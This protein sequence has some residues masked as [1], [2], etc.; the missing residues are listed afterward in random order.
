MR[1]KGVENVDTEYFSR[2]TSKTDELPIRNSFPDG[3]LFSIQSPPWF[4]NI[5]NFLV[6]WEM[7]QQ[8]SFQDKCKFLYEICQFFDGY[9]L[10]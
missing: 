6:A 3:Q 10:I 5:V 8:W 4:A 7:S 2:L 9:L 1:Q